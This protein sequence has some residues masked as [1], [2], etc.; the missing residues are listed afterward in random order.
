MAKSRVKLSIKFLFFCVFCFVSVVHANNNLII[1]PSGGDMT[2]H[3][4]SQQ[5]AAGNVTLKSSQGSASGVGNIIIRDTVTWSTNNTL[6]LDASNSVII[7]GSIAASGDTAGI[8]ITP[9]SSNS[10][11]TV[12]T[13]GVFSLSGS[14]I[15]LSG[16]TPSLSISGTS[17]TVITGLG[18]ST[19][20]TSPATGARTLQSMAATTNLAGNYALGVNIDASSTSTWNTNAGFTPI[21]N[22]SNNFTG[23]FNGLGHEIT[24]LT[25]NLPNNSS[26]GLFGLASSAA[27]IQN[28]GLQNATIT[29]Q[30]DTGALVGNNAGSISQSY[31]NSTVTAGSKV[32]NLVGVNLGGTIERSFASGQVSATSGSAGSL[33]GENTGVIKNCYAT[34]SVYGSGRNTTSGVGGLVGANKSNGTITTS[35]STGSVGSTNA[36]RGGLIG[37]GTSTSVTNGYWDTQTSNQ[38]T[39][40]AGSGLTTAEMMQQASFTGFDFTNIWTIVEGSTLPLFRFQRSNI[41]YTVDQL[42]L[43]ANDLSGDYE[44]GGDIDASATSTDT[45]VWG[46]DGFAPL[47]TSDTPFTGSLEG[48]GYKITG[49]MINLPTTDNVGLFGYTSSTATINDVSMVTPV[50]TG[51]HNV[52]ALVGNNSGTITVANALGVNVTGQGSDTGGVG[53]LVGTS[54]GSISNSYTSGNLTGVHNAGGLVGI[55]SGQIDSG[56]SSVAV[57]DVTGSAGG[58]VGA[59]ATGGSIVASYSS[60]RVSG[61]GEGATLGGLIG[62]NSGS[63]SFSNALGRIDCS[64]GSI[65]G[66]LIG[67]NGTSATVVGSIANTYATGSINGSGSSVGGLIGTNKSG[68]TVDKSYATVSLSNSINAGGLIGTNDGTVTNAY[69]NS[70]LVSTG[71][72]AG[73]AT[74]AGTGLS[75]ADM[76]ISS[77]FTGF[78]LTTTPDAQAWVVIN[79]DGSLQPAASSTAANTTAAATSPMLATEYLVGIT[80]THQLQLMAMAPS[81]S[82]EQFVDLDMHRTAK[83]NDVWGE[84]GFVPVGNSTT[85]FTGSFDG[86]G[87]LIS[88][89][90]IQQPVSNVGLF[91]R[92]GSATIKNVKML[93]ATVRGTNQVGALAGSFSGTA[94]NIYVDAYVSGLHTFTSGKGDDIGAVIGYNAGSISLSFSTGISYGGEDVGGLVGEN[95]GSISKSGTTT[96]TNARSSAG[97]AGGLVGHNKGTVSDSFVNGDVLAKKYAGGLIGANL[98]KV[99]NC[100]AR[101]LLLKAPKV[102]GLI[103]SNAN[104]VTSS[105]WDTTSSG[106]SSGTVGTGL[107]DSQMKTQSSFSGWD[108]TETWEMDTYPTLRNLP[109]R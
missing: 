78:A 100:Y 11:G 45:D 57:T 44:L 88:N 20:A 35:Y 66:G 21:G 55:N 71:I 54:S 63:A 38:T 32:G 4:L 18:V 43:I 8:V 46:S 77:N 15:T 69:W 65:C 62:I 79:K 26:V 36:Q 67:Q 12:T 92:V 106:V 13:D 28:V 22:G 91:G 94:E 51:Q 47:G 7:S 31:A 40:P 41:I 73:T 52:G 60:A 29:G 105:Y 1:A 76:R 75:S 68:S 19:D 24:G 27:K 97:Y 50:I 103:Q 74:T 87:F 82:Y 64:S 6:T 33:A 53:G 96:D 99:T 37:T 49:L 81:A 39:S 30:S 101:N 80:N 102:G 89:L 109:T 25:V 14:S 86:K 17:Y 61:V 107:S 3:A 16:S 48:N 108:F 98:G 2:G 93:N 83:E 104:T 95:T 42:Q 59:N 58:L 23:T 85:S 56:D 10:G 5:L 84:G 72:A 34:G 90:R 9:M 70:T